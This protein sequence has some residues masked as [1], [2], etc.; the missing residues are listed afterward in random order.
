MRMKKKSY[1]GTRNPETSE[2]ERRNRSVARRAAAEG[3][4][5]MKNE[6]VLPLKPGSRIALFGSGAGRTIKGGTGS[7]DVNERETVSIYQGLLNAGLEVSSS[8]W[9]QDYEKRY[10]QSRE[11]WK[12]QILEET[13]KTS[14]VNFFQVYAE[15]AY[16]M[17]DGRPI[18]ASDFEGADTAIYVISR[19]AG[20]GAD[21]MEEAGDYYLTQKEKEDLEAVCRY[22]DKVVVILNAGGQ[23]DLSQIRILPQVKALLFL[24]QPGME[25]GNAAA[26]VLTGAVVPSGKLTDTWAASYGDFPNAGTFSHQ[27]GDVVSEKYEEGIYVGYRYF[28]S[29]G[30]EPEYPFGFGLSYTE[31]SLEPET[32][33]VQS[34][35]QIE[36]ELCVKNVGTAYAGK[37]VAQIYVTPPQS[38]LPKEYQRL[39]AYEKTKLL[40]PG[41]SQRLTL[42]FPVK[43]LASFDEAKSAWVLEKGR[44]GVWAGNSSR[45]LSLAGV[46]EAEEDLILERVQHI[47]PLQE[48]LKEIA[49]DETLRKAMEQAWLEEANAKDIYPVKLSLQSADRTLGSASPRQAALEQEAG[50]LAEQLSDEELISMAVGEVSKSHNNTVGCAGVMVPGSAGETS[51]ILEEKWKV[52]GVPMADG[53]AGI[54]LIPK[55]E[56]DRESGR[57]YGG[58]FL[59]AMEGGIFAPKREETGDAYYQY[60]TAFPVGVLLA[61]T[62]DTK[63]LQEVGAAVAAEMLEFGVAW[64]LAPGMNIH[65]NPL[66]G[67]NFEYFSEDPLVSGKTAAAITR[68]VQSQEGVGTTI[69]HFACNNQEDNRLGSNSILS[70]RTLREIYLRGFEIAVKSA[71]PMA[72]MTSYNRINGVHSANNRDLCTVVARQE[73]NFQGFIMTDWTTTSAQGGSLAWKCMQAGND[74]IMPGEEQDKENIRQAL[75]NGQLSRDELR[76]CVK[77]L[78]KVIFQ[79]LVYEDCGIYGE[80]FERK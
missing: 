57:I 41:E 9:L 5:L 80:Q 39:C 2:R 19:I 34:G 58:G 21:R 15:H 30:V 70:E 16:R 23:I 29:F 40:S 37:E 76:S 12:N 68:G 1:S 53:P 7:G 6:G 18:Q 73:W 27:N 60:C 45:N 77:R 64:W 44:Y 62:W 11:D 78:L 35:N 54:R 72:I 36:I 59:E 56:V 42:S 79:T 65:R 66:C 4:V 32:L 38:G 25:G 52:P 10:Q 8:G 47:C 26:D 55:Y 43:N 31:F 75:E 71:Q 49:P 28:D 74:L 61:Q 46:L 3:I 50:K 22:C 51:G 48:E 13:D 69:K 63:L 33:C 67:R 14:V 17:P 24:A 20:E